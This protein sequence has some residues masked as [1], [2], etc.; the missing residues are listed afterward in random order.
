[1]IS[2]ESNVIPFP[3]RHRVRGGLMI[4]HIFLDTNE[5]FPDCRGRSPCRPEIESDDSPTELNIESVG[6]I[7]SLRGFAPTPTD[8]PN[9]V[10]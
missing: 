5:W 2:K 6:Y 8:E 10:P 3:D 9:A 4:H 7:F 1:M